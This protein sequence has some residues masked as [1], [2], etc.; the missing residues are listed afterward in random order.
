MDFVLNFSAQKLMRISLL[1]FLLILLSFFS[2]SQDKDN[3]KK[4][5]KKEKLSKEELL[6]SR[7]APENQPDHPIIYFKNL[8]K[9]GG[10][11][12]D[13]D[14]IKEIAKYEKKGDRDAMYDALYQYV[15]NFDIENFYRNTFFIWTL[16]QLA[17]EKAY[18]T[19]AESLYQY[20]IKHNKSGNSAMYYEKNSFLDLKRNPLDDYINIDEYYK[21]VDRRK[22]VDELYA[23]AGE[24][25]TLGSEVNDSLFSDYGPTLTKKNGRVVM[26]FTSKRNIDNLSMKAFNRQ[27]STLYANEDLYITTKADTFIIRETEE[28]TVVDTLKW[29][30]AQKLAGDINTDYNEGSAC[31]TKDGK[32][33]FFSR[34]D[35]PN[36]FGSCDIYMA[37][38]AEDDSSWV[39]IKNLGLNVNSIHWDSHPSLSHTEDTLYFA[40]DRLTGFGMSDIYFTYKIRDEGGDWTGE[41][42]KAQNLG[43]TVNTRFSEVSPFYHPRFDVLYFSSNGQLYNFGNKEMN[44][45]KIPT[46]DLYLSR[47]E[48]T[49]VIENGVE[50]EVTYWS[51]PKNTGPL[52]NQLGD[53][54]YF[55]IDEKSETIYFAKTDTTSGKEEDIYQRTFFME[56]NLYSYPLP[57]EAQ[58]EATTTLKG[59]IDGKGIVSII[60]L[61]NNGIEVAPKYIR[62]DGSYEFELIKN[63]RYL[64]VITGEDFFRIEQEFLLKGDTVIN[65]E[66]DPIK[67]KKW[68]FESV[69]FEGG[70]YDVTSD[71][72]PDLDK[73]VILLVD[74]EQLGL[75]ISGHTDS[76]GDEQKNIQ[77][78]QKRADAIRQYILKKSKVDESRVV[79]KGFGSSAPIVQDEKTEEDRQVNRRVEFELT[80]IN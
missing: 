49:K 48:K 80:R 46:F 40:S 78:S 11:Y 71:M 77:L 60:H 17:E 4:K 52:I 74:N 30:P 55:A 61:D 5:D 9:L 62:E 53:E 36:S 15:M 66:T 57:M 6:T 43:P 22:N 34:C 45:Q 39:D 8:N 56:M 64:I 7:N 12:Y 2:F 72:Y 26:I 27:D 51:E 28:G 69:R 38:L 10:Y 16:A 1:C 19:Q 42:A 75:F 23:T 18:N 35:D 25:R 63:N 76:V 79:A 33:I 70:K 65:I 50:K 47:K 3:K 58:P 54:Y 44:M 24:N 29:H 21:I 73:L 37:R 13:E 41:W 68:R 67:F 31:L 20:V 32:Y 14:K 59:V